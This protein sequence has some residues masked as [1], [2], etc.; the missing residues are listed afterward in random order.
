MRWAVILA[1]GSGTRFWPLSSPTHPKQLLPLAGPESTAEAA[2]DR[3]RGLVPPERI[4]LVTGA[5]LAGPLTAKLAVPGHNVLIEPEAKST[6]PALVWGTWVARSRDPGAVVLS[7]HAD[8][9]VPD[10]AGF[11]RSAD[12]ALTLAEGAGRLVTVGVV[13]TRPE[14]GY[15]YIVPGSPLDGG[16]TVAQFTEKPSVA[17]A[18]K[19]IAGGALWNSG[20]FAWRAD[21]FLAEI[22]RHTP[23]IAPAL[24]A[25]ARADV[26]AFF[27][28][29][30]EVSIDVGLLERSEA[31]AVVPGRF[32]WDDIGTWEALA[33][34]RPLDQNGNVLVGNVT[35]VGARDSIGW[36]DRIPI[37]LAGVANVVV[38]EA[39]GRILVMDRR[40]AADLKR[41]L[42]QLP[43]AVRE[44]P[45]P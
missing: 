23:E 20:L 24:P 8:W 43:N 44:T 29:C 12:L 45:A 40:D 33:R 4:L 16:F 6:G 18:E 19:L 36:S 13:P 37:V 7:T 1:G 26:A 42:E 31:V 9:H 10:A 35:A 11:A 38:V 15:G 25:L 28:Q 21:T 14:T 22:E 17:G 34:V 3:L 41:I 2:F 5:R 32:A 39:N 30:R 27:G